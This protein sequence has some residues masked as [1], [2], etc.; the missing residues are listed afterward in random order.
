LKTNSRAALSHF[1]LSLTAIAHAEGK[2]PS[3]PVLHVESGTAEG[4]ASGGDWAPLAKGAF[5]DVGLVVRTSDDFA[6]QVLY[7]DG[8]TLRVRPG[9]S[10]QLLDDGLRLMVGAVWIKVTRSGSTFRMETPGA[11]A[12]VRGTIFTGEVQGAR[13]VFRTAHREESAHTVHYRHAPVSNLVGPVFGIAV[14][15]HLLEQISGGAWPTDVDVYEGVVEFTRFETA[16]GAP[17]ASWSLSA[18]QGAGLRGLDVAV[19]AIPASRYQKWGMPVPAPRG[20]GSGQQ[21]PEGRPVELLETTPGSG[22]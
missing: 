7:G 19:I 6:G 22:R 20:S 17:A 9:S 12:S 2:L 8:T 15:A 5:L 10:L 21:S 1:V 13:E 14:A 11:V 4:R 18:G 16:T 3:A